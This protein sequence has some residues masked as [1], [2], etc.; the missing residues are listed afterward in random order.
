MSSILHVALCSVKNIIICTTEN[1]Y[2]VTVGVV[3]IPVYGAYRVYSMPEARGLQC[4]I[5]S[6]CNNIEP[7]VAVLLPIYC[8]ASGPKHLLM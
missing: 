7:S 8:S 6:K 2:T 5:F 1:Q 4:I 3:L